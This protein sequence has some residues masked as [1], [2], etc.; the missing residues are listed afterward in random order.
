MLFIK[1]VHSTQ[2]GFTLITFLFA[3]SLLF[4]FLF[5][6]FFFFTRIT[7]ISHPCTHLSWNQWTGNLDDIF[8]AWRYWPSSW[9]DRQTWMCQAK[10]LSRKRSLIIHQTPN[11]THL[12]SKH[13]SQED[14][15]FMPRAAT[16]SLNLHNRSEA[17]NCWTHI[18]LNSNVFQFFVCTARWRGGKKTNKIAIKSVQKISHNWK[19]V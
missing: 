9:I 11:C 16:R 8:S 2:V 18:S 10:H 14:W 15:Q 17:R 6:F 1:Q 19:Q 4:S 12:R 7:K 3:F 13:T 5:F